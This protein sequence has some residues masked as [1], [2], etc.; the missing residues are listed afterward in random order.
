[1]YVRQIVFVFFP[2]CIT[3]KLELLAFHKF[4]IKLPN[5]IIKFKKEKLKTFA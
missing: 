2:C 5:Y 3:L 1:M 4:A